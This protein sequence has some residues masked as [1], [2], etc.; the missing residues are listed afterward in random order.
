MKLINILL[1]KKFLYYRKGIDNR[2]IPFKEENP[3][4]L[5]Y[6]NITN[7]HAKITEIIN[8]GNELK[9]Y[10]IGFSN[11][12]IQIINSFS[13][14][15]PERKGRKIKLPSRI[16]ILMVLIIYTKLIYGTLTTI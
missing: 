7:N 11:D 8:I 13:I 4:L 12:I 14:F 5:N 6:I 9:Y 2:K 15:Y 16:I 1:K 3:I 10:R